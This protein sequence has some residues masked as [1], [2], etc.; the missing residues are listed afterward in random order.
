MLRYTTSGQETER[1]NS[2]NPRACTGRT[3][4]SH[5]WF[6]C[7]KS[8]ELKQLMINLSYKQ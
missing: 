1:V 2:Y 4:Q 6:I 8:W 3:I 7:Y 5:L